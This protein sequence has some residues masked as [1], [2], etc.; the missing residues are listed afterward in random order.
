M[1]PPFLFVTGH[2]TNFNN[3]VRKYTPK[4][5]QT[6]EWYKEY[7]AVPGWFGKEKKKKL[8][9][10]E[11]VDVT[12]EMVNGKLQIEK[13]ENVFMVEKKDQMKKYYS[14][15]HLDLESRVYTVHLYFIVMCC[16]LFMHKP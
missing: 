14:Y 6:T 16:E 13:I 1:V 8:M 9:N 11:C 10:A 7:G 15:V 3:F 12:L 5:K 2:G 4:S